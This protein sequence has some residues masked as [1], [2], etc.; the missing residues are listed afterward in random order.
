[1]EI[2]IGACAPVSQDE[3]YYAVAFCDG[4]ETNMDQVTPNLMEEELAAPVTEPAKEIDP[5]LIPAW[6]IIPPPRKMDEF[7]CDPNPV[8]NESVHKKSF[9]LVTVA[10]ALVALGTLLNIIFTA[11]SGFIAVLEYQN[12]A[13][14]LPGFVQVGSMYKH[15]WGYILAS[16]AFVPL[17]VFLIISL[18]KGISL[19]RNKGDIYRADLDSFARANGVLSFY[20]IF[21]T[22]DVAMVGLA[23]FLL[24]FAVETQRLERVISWMGFDKMYLTT[25]LAAKVKLWAA[26]ESLLPALFA[27]LIALAVIVYALVKVTTYRSMVGYYREISILAEYRNSQVDANPPMIR[28]IAVSALNLVFA[29]LMAINGLYVSAFMLVAEVAYF[30]ASL[31][32]MRKLKLDIDASRQ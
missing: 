2:N 7:I 23:A 9:A 3:T 13:L 18:V 19:I 28:M 1:M 6:D 4:M 29:V 16:L 8:M 25:G 24:P 22:V 11:M 21:N 12:P 20:A 10:L 14:N 15:T 26:E 31:L 32:Y 5:L 30:I 17:L 27:G